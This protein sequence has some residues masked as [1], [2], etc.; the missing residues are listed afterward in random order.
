MDRV[1]SLYCRFHSLSGFI[2]EMFLEMQNEEI[3]P[4]RLCGFLKWRR[5]IPLAVGS[6]VKQALFLKCFM[7]VQC[8]GVCAYR[9]ECFKSE[10]KEF[11][12]LRELNS[13]RLKSPSR[14]LQDVRGLFT[15]YLFL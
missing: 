5:S 7:M 4:R 2:L 1:G 6:I 10:E 12:S 14:L 3:R 13:G 15:F 9:F 8:Y 11:R